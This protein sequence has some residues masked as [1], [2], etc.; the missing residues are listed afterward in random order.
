[1]PLT[2][3]STATAISPPIRATSLFTAEARPACWDGAEARAVAVRGATVMARPRP[4][5]TT[6]GST[7]VR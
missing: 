2:A 1:M 3:G 4:N 5:T 6:A 7:P